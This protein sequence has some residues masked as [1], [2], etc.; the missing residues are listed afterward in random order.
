MD[1]G[2]LT[3]SCGLTRRLRVWYNDPVLPGHTQHYA[4]FGA[5]RLPIGV[6]GGVRA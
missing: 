2:D 1:R 4:P 3:T 5:L 6:R